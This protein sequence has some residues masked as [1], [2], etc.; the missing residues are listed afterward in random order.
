MSGVVPRV[1]SSVVGGEVRVGGGVPGGTSVAVPP[2]PFTTAVGASD[3]AAGPT[4][5]LRSDSVTGSPRAA[6]SAAR[7]RSPADG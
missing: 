6:A 5:T 1:M 7:P 4:A 2:P 3:G